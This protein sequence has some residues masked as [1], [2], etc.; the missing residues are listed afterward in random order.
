MATWRERL[1]QLMADRGLSA[2]ELSRR[3]GVNVGMIHD[4]IRRGT[5]P[6]VANLIKI[7]NALG[8]GAG[9]LVD[10]PGGA[11]PILSVVGVAG[12]GEMWRKPAPGAARNI[13]LDM[14]ADLVAVEIQTRDFEPR[15]NMGDVI[16]GPRAVGASLHNL[17]GSECIVETE[18]GKR[19][20]KF[21]TAGNK[22]GFYSLR[23][24]NARTPDLPNV[25]IA[26]A[27]PIRLILR[28]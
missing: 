21:L 7:A 16:A 17:L 28:N 20:V 22:D 6:P 8:V 25:K 23:S 18:D 1:T 3:A 15:Y 10:G 14:F 5:V 11:A 24:A 4:I 9:Y 26:F 19:L 12:D 2:A 13:T 27:A